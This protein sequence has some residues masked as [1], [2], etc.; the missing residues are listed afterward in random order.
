MNTCLRMRFKM[1]PEDLKIEVSGNP[2]DMHSYF[3]KITHKPTGIFGECNSYCDKHYN[4]DGSSK[5]IVNHNIYRDCALFKLFN[6]FID[7]KAI[8]NLT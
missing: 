4:G 5:K 8:Q 3:Y 1:N 7:M 2:I 6:K